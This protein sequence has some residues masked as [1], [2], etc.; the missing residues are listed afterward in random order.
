MW[1]RTN[2]GRQLQRS[3]VELKLVGTPLIPHDDFITCNYAVKDIYTR[4]SSAHWTIVNLPKSKQ[5]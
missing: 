3:L 2:N 4:L 5:S 1:R